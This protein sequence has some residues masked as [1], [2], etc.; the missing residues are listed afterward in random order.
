MNADWYTRSLKNMNQFALVIGVAG[1]AFVLVNAGWRP[2]FGFALGAAIS[3]INFRLWKR[4]VNSVGE[5]SG[6]QGSAGLLGMRYVLIGAAVFA[7]MRVLDV[8]ALAVLG[9]LLVTVAAALVEITRQLI[10]GKFS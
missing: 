2:A 6:A 8:S 9:G 7:I 10:L 4:V 5:P 1:T 3:D